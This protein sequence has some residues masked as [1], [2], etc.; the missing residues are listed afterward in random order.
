MPEKKFPK[1]VFEYDCM[2]ILGGG[3]YKLFLFEDGQLIKEEHDGMV[4]YLESNHPGEF[5]TE[6][7]KSPALAKDI[8]QLIK[9]NEE[10]LKKLPKEISNMNIIDGAYET[11]KFGSLKIEGENILTKSL[12]GYKEYL[13]KNN[14]IEM[15][16]EEDLLKFQRIF[17]M[18]QDKFHE[19]VTE[20]LFNED[21]EER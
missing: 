11:F 21:E 5:G 1:L 8:K 3:N 9:E 17:K 13:K 4:E 15:G 2:G 18:F 16:W 10:A 7:V 19:Y 14:A 12:E 6:I 20:P